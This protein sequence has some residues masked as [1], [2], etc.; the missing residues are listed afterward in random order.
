VTAGTRSRRRPRPT[1]NGSSAM[2]R[3]P[4]R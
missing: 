3:S 4:S 2:W 1:W